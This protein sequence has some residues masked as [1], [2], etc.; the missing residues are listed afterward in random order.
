[1]AAQLIVIAKP[2]DQETG[3]KPEKE[4]EERGKSGSTAAGGAPIGGKDPYGPYWPIPVGTLNVYGQK[5]I[6]IGHFADMA[7]MLDAVHLRQGLPGG[8]NTL[9]ASV[10]SL[11]NARTPNLHDRLKALPDE[12]TI[13]VHEAKH[14]A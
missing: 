8:S 9:F 2:S 1:M 5:P 3:H 10:G 7:A 14:L 6:D 13:I 11:H 12:L 4:P